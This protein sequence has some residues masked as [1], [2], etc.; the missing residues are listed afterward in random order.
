VADLSRSQVS[1]SRRSALRLLSEELSG[2]PVP[3]AE[4]RVNHKQTYNVEIIGLPL[5]GSSER[6]KRAALTVKPRRLERCCSLQ[7]NEQFDA[8]KDSEKQR[9][10]AYGGYKE[11]LER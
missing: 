7:R 2:S 3:K 5:T 6:P 9:Y 10:E 11:Q 4:V 1:I 8:P